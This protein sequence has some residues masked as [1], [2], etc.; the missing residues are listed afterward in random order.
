M[1]NPIKPTFYCTE[2]MPRSPSLRT[3]VIFFSVLLQ[4][5]FLPLI[6]VFHEYFLHPADWSWIQESLLQNLK[7]ME[8][9]IQMKSILTTV[10]VCGQVQWQYIKKC[11]L[12]VDYL[13]GFLRLNYYYFSTVLAPES[14]LKRITQHFRIH[15]CWI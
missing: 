10:Y 1:L 7:G 9:G 13:K 8:K 12:K 15:V 4:I 6:S 11:Q 14:Q 3:G 5:N 2:N